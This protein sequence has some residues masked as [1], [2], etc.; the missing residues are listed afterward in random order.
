MLFHHL[1]LVDDGKVE[2]IW[3]CV[4]G[5]GRSSWLGCPQR[6]DHLSPEQGHSLSIILR[7]SR[8]SVFFLVSGLRYGFAFRFGSALRSSSV[9]RSGQ[10]SFKILSG[11]VRAQRRQHGS[12]G[13]FLAN[14]I[15]I[16]TKLKTT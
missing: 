12:R 5:W 15:Q 7:R 14:Y 11:G 1:M 6:A 8:S 10:A 13:G 2:W 16:N 3:V 4:L 9:F